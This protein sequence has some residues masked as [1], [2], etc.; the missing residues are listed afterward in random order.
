MEVSPYEEG[1]LRAASPRWSGRDDGGCGLRSDRSTIADAS[2]SY[3][4]SKLAQDPERARRLGTSAV[5]YDTTYVGYL[6]SAHSR[7]RELAG[8]SSPAP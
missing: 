4:H 8:T 7:R 3:A 5:T 2:A 1:F 6:G